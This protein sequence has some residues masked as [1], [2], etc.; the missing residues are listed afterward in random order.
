MKKQN[1]F[2]RFLK[3][4]PTKLYIL[5]ALIVTCSFFSNDFGLVDIQKTA[6]I[7]A[8]GVDRTEENFVMTAQIAVPKGTERTTGGTS[9]VEIS[10]EGATVSDCVADIYSKTG[11]VPKFIF[12][13]LIILSE[14][15]AKERTFGALDFFLRN[16]YMSDSCLVAVC[17]GSAAELL[18]SVSAIDDTSSMAISQLFSS[19]AE[20]S[21]KTV[22]NTLKEFTIGYNSVSKSSYLPYIRMEKQEG[23]ESS[24]QA[25]GQSGSGSSGGS[26]QEE[27]IYT[28]EETALFYDGVM[29]G[30]LPPEQT[31]AFNLLQGSVLAG[32]ITV[33][34]GDMNHSLSVLKN[35]GGVS[36]EVKQN[37]S[38][39]F[40]VSL[41]VKLSSCCSSAPIAG[42]TFSEIPDNVLEKAEE[43][44]LTSVQGLWE[45]CKESG[46]DMFLL[47]RELYRSSLKKYAEWK[48]VL[49][50]SV[51]PE[52]K[53]EINS[54]K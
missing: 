53:I 2:K 51:E 31:Y 26:E 20:K 41:T 12:C 48:D 16:E 21:G 39:E 47:T 45:S 37:P 7:L 4:I 22:K 34:E 27:K 5:L 13:D 29:V 42:M 10:G 35:E 50:S 15:T 18:S 19:S 1:K 36:L 14:K 17:E 28:A 8:A 30:I 3:T 43:E 49:L 38:I 32:E 6:I 44:I 52:F 33:K 40:F 25:G 46:C 23:G 24:S 11:W 9:S 54:T